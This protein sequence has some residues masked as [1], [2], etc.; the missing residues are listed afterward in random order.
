M[1]Q[2]QIPEHLRPARAHP[3]DDLRVRWRQGGDLY[4]TGRRLSALM[5]L[6]GDLRLVSVGSSLHISGA[7]EAVLLVPRPPDKPLAV[8]CGGCG[9]GWVFQWGSGRTGWVQDSMAVAVE[10]RAALS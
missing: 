5:R 7:G 2:Q 10:I 4:S 8:L 6:M 1:S 3:V 9:D